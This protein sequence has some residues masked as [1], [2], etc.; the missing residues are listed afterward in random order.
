MPRQAL[1]TIYRSFFRLPHLDY[2]DIIYDQSNNESFCKTLESYQCNATLV[3]TD[4][5]RRTSQTKIYKKIG[6]E[7][8]KIQKILGNTQHIFQD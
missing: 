4:V 5:V 7:S 1:L 6:L 3:V 8:F 2:E